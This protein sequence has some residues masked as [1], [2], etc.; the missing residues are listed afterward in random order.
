MAF[1]SLCGYDRRRTPSAHHDEE[2][3]SIGPCKRLILPPGGSEKMHADDDNAGAV[4]CA[5][6]VTPTYPPA[7][8]IGRSRWQKISKINVQRL[9]W[10]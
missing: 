1:D 2:L 4:E 6:S 10:R 3:R 8:A 9:P 5:A 7:A